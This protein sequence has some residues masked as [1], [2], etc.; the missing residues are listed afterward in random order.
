M[1]GSDEFFAAEDAAARERAK[2]NGHDGGASIEPL[3]PI[4]PTV[5]HGVP[6]PDRPWLVPGWVPMV[7]PTGL[8]GAGGE[9]KTLIAQQLATACAIGTEWLGLPARRCT[10]LLIY[11]EDDRDEMHRRQD[12]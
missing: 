9:G 5:L 4:D 1:I 11:C 3:S 6:V 2:P 10:S 7:R 12:D 8:Y